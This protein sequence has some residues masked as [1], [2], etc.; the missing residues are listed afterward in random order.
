MSSP[1]GSAPVASSSVTDDRQPFNK[2][3]HY[4][5]AL[6]VSGMEEDETRVEA[7]EALMETWVASN[8][9]QAAEWAGSLPAGTFRDDALSSLMMHWAASAPAAA[10]AWMSRTGVDDSEAASVLASRWAAQDPAAAAAWSATLANTESRRTA[11][12]SAAAAWA[13]SAPA[14]A[15]DF[16]ENLPA[17]DRT[18]AITA[19]LAVWANTAPAQAGV[20]LNGTAFASETD[21]A[22][23]VAALVTPWT[24]QSPAAVSKYINS[25]P[26][27]P[28]REAAAS[29]FAVTAAPT[30]PAEAL[31]WAM[32]IRDPDQ[33]NQ[34]VSD[35]CESWFNGSPDTFRSGIAEAIGLMEDPAMRRGVYEMLYEHDPAFHDNLLTLADPAPATVLTTPAA[36]PENT[37]QPPPPE[38]SARL[39]PAPP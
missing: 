38:A 9:R 37:G 15:A 7:I 35:S 12:G 31:M 33:R 22:V 20:W 23:A 21:R 39:F 2:S 32:N 14:A 5:A 34:V 26:D 30:A 28:A 36:A 24:A 16:A 29:Q 4:A 25:L 11:L 10:A 13:A 6:T 18:A 1:P 8:P 3:P 27:G 17:A 19:V